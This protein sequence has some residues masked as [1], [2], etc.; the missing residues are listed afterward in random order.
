MVK[1]A[2][3]TTT[4]TVTIEKVNSAAKVRPPIQRVKPGDMV[5]FEL[6]GFNEGDVFFFVRD[7]FGRLHVGLPTAPLE[8]QN[9][10]KGVYPYLPVVRR[11][12][13][14]GRIEGEVV[15]EGNSMPVFVMD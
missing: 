7:L 9:A 11:R 8:V 5:E 4:Y 10:P 2:T 15:A 1:S 12:L 6:I 3:N 13:D 14:D